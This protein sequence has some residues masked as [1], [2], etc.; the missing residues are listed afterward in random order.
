MTRKEQIL[1]AASKSGVPVGDG[2]KGDLKDLITAMADEI[3]MLR[4]ALGFYGDQR[5]WYASS[6]GWDGGTANCIQNDM[7]ATWSAGKRARQAL[8]T[9][10]ALDALLKED[11]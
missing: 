11:K 4:E 3:E 8:S 9:P 5:N 6:P 2:N 1:K 7:D 10:N